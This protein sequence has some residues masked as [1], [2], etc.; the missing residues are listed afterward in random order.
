M[1][2][3]E[4]LFMGREY[5]A[6]LNYV[7]ECVNW[8]REQPVEVLHRGLKHFADR[9]LVAIGSGGSFGAA[10]FA[11][12]QHSIHFGR[13]SQSITP[14]QLASLPEDASTFGA[15]LISSE[16]KNKDILAGATQLLAKGCPAL[17]LTLTQSNPLVRLCSQTGAATVAGYEMPWGKDGYLSTNSLIA[18]LVLIWRAYNLDCDVRFLDQLLKWRATLQAHFMTEVHKLGSQKRVLIL[19]SLAGRIGAIDLESRLSEAAI[20]F[21]QTCDYRQFAHGRHLQLAYPDDISVVAICDDSDQLAEATLALLPPSFAVVKVQLPKLPAALQEI[22]SVLASMELVGAWASAID[23]DPGHPDVPQFGRDLHALDV[24]EF[25]PMPRT[26]P[27]TLR[28]RR[29]DAFNETYWSEQQAQ[30]VKSLG[31]ARFKGLVCDFDGT[32]C[33]TIRRY[34]KVLEPRVSAELTRILYAGI[35]VAF[36]TGRGDSLINVIRKSI[37][38]RLWPLVT[39]GCYSG[40]AIFTLDSPPNEFPSSDDKFSSLAGHLVGHGIVASLDDCKRDCGQM[41]LRSLS[42]RTKQQVLCAFAEW[43]RLEGIT[44]WRAFFSGH[45]VDILNSQTSK[46]N[47]VQ[48][49]AKRLGA[50][51]D[52][53]ILRLGDAGDVGGND[54]ELL[55]EGISLSV[56]TCSSN[57]SHCWNLL[58]SDRRGMQGTLFYLSRLQF[59]DGVAVFDTSCF[60]GGAKA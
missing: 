17:A 13:I 41:S 59:A 24:R 7:P 50:S 42:Q 40:S 49:L 16:G 43:S 47:V 19:H 32:F 36:A 10:A 48:A 1:V 60:D 55:S 33:D 2:Y 28:K 57:P 46:R 54:Y 20:A 45:S 6:E 11:A 58:P 3:K 18:T 35:P 38:E 21:G 31:T 22:A 5:Q 14:L 44:G 15:L 34:D 8:A 30:F 12:A 27:P 53:E 52:R 26:V 25:L 4:G 39:L 23:R 51:M 9:G 56:D 37:D 29:R